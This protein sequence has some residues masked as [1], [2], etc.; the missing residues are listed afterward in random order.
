MRAL[1]GWSHGHLWDPHH[2]GREGGHEHPSQRGNLCRAGDA[3]LAAVMS[4]YLPSAL[5]A[6]HGPG[7]LA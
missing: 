5:R 4:K 3:D 7:V 6:R 1:V 2:K